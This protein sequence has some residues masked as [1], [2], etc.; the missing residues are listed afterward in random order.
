M[1]F[2]SVCNMWVRIRLASQGDAHPRC[3]AVHPSFPFSHVP[4]RKG[5]YFSCT[6]ATESRFAVFRSTELREKHALC[7]FMPFDTSVADDARAQLSWMN[8]AS[9]CGTLA[10]TS[11][12]SPQAPPSR[13]ESSHG[14]ATTLPGPSVHWP[15]H[16]RYSA[17]TEQLVPCRTNML[18]LL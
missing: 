14:P 13:R 17:E 12:H 4:V 10:P 5:K 8:Q 11:G 2:T 16:R 6:F 7:A 9:R 18:S 3:L 15:F 1:L